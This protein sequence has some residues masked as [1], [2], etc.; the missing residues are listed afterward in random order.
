MNR[1]SLRVSIILLLTTIMLLFAV[2]VPVGAEAENQP[3]E[4][5]IL[6]TMD[7]Q[8]DVVLRD[9]FDGPTLDLNVWEP[10]GHG[11]TLTFVDG[12]LVINSGPT[13]GLG[14]GI[15]SL[16]TFDLSDGTWILEALVREQVDDGGRSGFAF[17]QQNIVPGKDAGA[18]MGFDGQA[19]D[20]NIGFQPN[21]F[22]VN[23]TAVV[24]A[25]DPTDW[26]IWRIEVDPTEARFYM[27]GEFLGS[28]VN[29][30]PRVALPIYISRVSWDYAKTLELDYLQLLHIPEQVNQPPDCS[31]AIPS[32]DTLWPPNHEF[33]PI[34]VL[35]VTDPEGD[36]ISITIGS[37]FQD[38]PVDTE[39]DGS[40]APDGQGVGSPI[41]EVRAER[42]GSGNGRFYHIGFTANDGNG[43]TCSGVVLVG[44]PK[45][46]GNN[47]APVDDGPLYDSTSLTP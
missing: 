14:K 37:I 12:V 25:P 20:A 43:G 30:D 13:P 23:Q 4:S 46:Q 15:I 24:P 22:S 32:A 26:L 29:D 40:F 6:A 9:D 17:Y 7:N 5:K 38:E 28:F 8:P 41:A 18:G 35:G 19:P 16:E 33:A 21:P 1:K 47:G 2:A 3:F 11:G 10:I 42:V 27:G 36:P 31:D 39:G 45:S 44:V 34:E